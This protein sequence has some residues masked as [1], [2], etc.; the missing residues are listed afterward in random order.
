M[1]KILSIILLIFIIL[2]FAITVNA[3]NEVSNVKAKVVEIEEIQEIEK[4]NAP[5]QKVQN[6]TV[7]ILEGEYENEEYEMQHIIT[8]DI[9]SITYNLELKQDESVIVALE[10]KEGEVTNVSYIETISN[11]YIIYMICIIL[12]VLLLIISRKRATL[13]YLITIITI[14]CTL[15]LSIKNGWNLIL[16]S[17][18][19]SLLTTIILYISINKMTKNTLFK[20]IKTILGIAVSGILI[21][22]LLDIMNLVNVNIKIVDNFVNLKDL[23]I[24]SNIL[25]GC[26][27]YNS[28]AIS[29]E[30]IFY[31]TNKPYKT[32]SDNIIEGQR[33]LKL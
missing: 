25:I 15:I 29:A 19:L 4:E 32:K 17:S 14:G 20:I 3:Q 30:Y 33:S 9:E 7:R 6:V 18:I 31:A 24:S 2:T 1:K 16:I 23:I 26:G 11:S 27:I 12:I 28:I 13:V 8:E 5:T 21:Y 10:E 22:S